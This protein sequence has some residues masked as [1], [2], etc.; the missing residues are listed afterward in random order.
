MSVCLYVCV[1]VCAPGHVPVLSLYVSVCVCVCVCAPGHVP[2]LSVCVCMCVCVC[3]YVCVC[4]S[5]PSHTAVG[6]VGLIW[7][8]LW[9]CSLCPVLFRADCLI[10]DFSPQPRCPDFVLP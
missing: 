7:S 5:S 10:S 3:L 4:V 1:C 8:K 9:I 6:Y 2:V